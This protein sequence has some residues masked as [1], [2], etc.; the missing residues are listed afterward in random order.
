M[1]EQHKHTPLRLVQ[2]PGREKNIATAKE[3]W[4]HIESL[5]RLRS[6]DRRSWPVPRQEFNPE[7]GELIP[8]SETERVLRA[9]DMQDEDRRRLRTTMWAEVTLRDPK[10][11]DYAARFAEWH[12]TEWLIAHVPDEST[13]RE[14]LVRSQ[15]K[16]LAHG[17]V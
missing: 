14:R 11:K 3:V 12:R 10:H 1:T 4:A 2:D 7:T 9:S 17:K 15:V 8:L 16:L 13:E 5:R 6:Q